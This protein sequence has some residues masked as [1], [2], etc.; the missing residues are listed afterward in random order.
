MEIWDTLVPTIVNY[1]EDNCEHNLKPL[2][3]MI[4]ESLVHLNV[5]ILKGESF[6]ELS[7]LNSWLMYTTIEAVTK[8]PKDQG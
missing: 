6:E 1:Q 3:L 5:G 7:G 8:S 4:N 2:F